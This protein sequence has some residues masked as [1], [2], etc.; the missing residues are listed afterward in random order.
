MIISLSDYLGVDSKIFLQK[1][2]LNPFIGID[3]RSFVDPLLVR[4]CIIP[5]FASA[6]DKINKYFEEI[7]TLLSASEKQDDLAW[8]EAYHRLIFREVKGASIGYG[9]N[10]ADGKGIGPK[11]AQELTNRALELAKLGIKDPAIFELIG[12]FIDDYGPDMLSDMTIRILEDEFLT[13]SERMYKE[14]GVTKLFKYETANGIREF[15]R[16]KKGKPIILLPESM[17]RDLPVAQNWEDIA[18]IVAHN[19]LLRKRLNALI[20]PSLKEASIAHRKELMKSQLFTHSENLNEL[21]K[22]YKNYVATPYDFKKDPQGLL[23]WHNLAQ[24]YCDND[25]L[26]ISLQPIP[27]IDDIEDTVLQIINKFK[28]HIELNG[29]NIHLY[30]SEKK[31]PKPLHERFSQTLFY[32]TADNYCDA[33]NIGLT[34]ES[35]A[36]RGPVDFKFN[37]GRL[38][39]IVEVKLSKSAYLVRGYTEQLSIYQKAENASRT[40]YVIIRVSQEINSIKTIQKLEKDVR[41]T[42]QKVPRLIVIDGRLK[43]S[44]SKKQIF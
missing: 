32:A 22:E 33:N 12:L 16:N 29:L 35:N 15:A 20:A 13:F 3:S 5:E 30:N 11:L 7:I 1:G 8:T 42:G 19:E 25:K 4:D 23:K 10:S 28:K 43:P 34:R 9:K 17:L 38:N 21:I 27:T 39:C 24:Q 18:T 36:G 44:A 40:I 14:M 26:E 37:N 2:I 41:A 31:P 6:R